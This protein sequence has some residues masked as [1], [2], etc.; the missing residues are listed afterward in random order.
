MGTFGTKSK[1]ELE[2]NESDR[3]AKLN[4]RFIRWQDKQITLLTFSI[5]L[6]F[7]LSVAAIGLIINNF[8]N[9][10]LKENLFYGYPLPKA[11]AF[12]LSL[13]MICGIIALFSRLFDFRFTKNKIRARKNLFQVIKGIKYERCKEFKKDKLEN[14][15]KRLTCWMAFFGDMTWIFFILQALIFV[16]S[17]LVFAYKI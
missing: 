4:E 13:S 15:I 2:P 12:F 14:K 10:L 7:T 5:N 3:L 8:D 17:I 6:F 1:Y 11:T 16:S 9:A